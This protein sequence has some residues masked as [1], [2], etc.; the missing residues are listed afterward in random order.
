MVVVGVALLA[1][2]G[3]AA[4]GT[5]AST[6]RVTTSDVVDGRFVRAVVLD[7][8]VLT[9]RPAPAS[10]RTPAN[11]VALSRQIWATSQV[12]GYRQQVLGF[13]VVTITTHVA[14]VATVTGVPAW[15]GFAMNQ[16]VVSCPNEP[17]GGPAPPLN[18]GEAAVVVGESGGSPAVVY[19]ARSLRCSQVQPS[20]LVNA[21]E[22]ISLAWAA[23]GPRRV[24]QVSGVTQLAIDVAPPPCQPLSASHLT[25]HVEAATG[26]SVTIAVDGLAT[27]D[28]LQW[29]AC[30]VTL[31]LRRWVSIGRAAPTI[32]I[33]HA[34]IGAVRLVTRRST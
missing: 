34:P 33:R 31:P 7:G 17:V 5:G 27:Q 16:S 26:R 12:R 11:R 20:R 18:G 8:G 14:S 6:Q 13:G 9:V 23:A 4:S 10:M 3:I 15:V 32:T 24:N 1:G 25:W 2:S 28:T 22:E 30:P 19:I 29:Q 21:T